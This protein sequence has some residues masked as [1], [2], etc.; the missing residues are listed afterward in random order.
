MANVLTAL[1]MA[2]GGVTTV[3]KISIALSGAYVQYVASPAAGELIDLS[4]IVNT[5][6]I[7]GFKSF[8]DALIAGPYQLQVPGGYDVEFIPVS[9]Q[10]YQYYM[11]VYTTSATELA[12]ATYPAGIIAATA[13]SSL[14]A[15]FDAKTLA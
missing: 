11:K 2:V 6:Q 14:I 13:L 1:S 9:G 5:P 10:P 3:R 7:D 12:A 8:L 4:L 15:G